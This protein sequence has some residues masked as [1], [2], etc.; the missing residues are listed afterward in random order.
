[1]TPVTGDSAGVKGA[2]VTKRAN[3][4]VQTTFSAPGVGLRYTT[5]VTGPAGYAG[6]VDTCRLCQLITKYKRYLACL[7]QGASERHQRGRPRGDRRGRGLSGRY[8]N[9]RHNVQVVGDGP[10]DVQVFAVAVDGVEPSA[11]LPAY[12][13]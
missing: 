5:T 6:L 4:R 8:R 2:H 13:N 3:G 7:C 12:I 11:E 1:V 9:A 10:A